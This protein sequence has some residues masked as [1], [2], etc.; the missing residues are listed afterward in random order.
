MDIQSLSQTCIVF[1]TYKFCDDANVSRKWENI[2]CRSIFRYMKKSFFP[3]ILLFFLSCTTTPK[4]KAFSYQAGFKTIR[5]V[6]SS[7]TYKPLTDT[8]DYLHFRPLDLD[9][10]YPAEISNTDSAILFKDFLGLLE[11]RANY[12]T[13]S[14]AANGLT[15]QMAQSCCEGFK[16]SDP[17]KLLNYRT[18]SYRNAKASGQTFPLVIYLASYNSMCYENVALF[19]KL[20][21][22]GYVVLSINS[23]GRYPGDMTMKHGDMMEQVFDAISS[24]KYLDKNTNIDFS[25]IGIVGYSWGG[26]SGTVLANK[27]PNTACLISFDGSEFHHYGESKDE[28][29]DFN[30]IRESADF[31]NMRLQIPYLRLE[32]APLPGTG[33][34]SNVYNFTEKLAGDRIILTIDSTEHQD[35]CSLPSFV[36]ESGNCSNPKTFTT[37]TNLAISF[38]DEHLK[39]SNS[40]SQ[41]LQQELDKTVRQK[42]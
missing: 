8:S 37:I 18:S 15:K 27:I 20:A 30:G 13:A 25:K 5:T 22:N 39:R 21:S 41:T 36:K 1:A 14:T 10:W 4:E 42:N 9:I 38:L 12:Y 19:E 28:D 7:R 35:F 40:F 34:N 11:Q 26:L 23:I 32:S 29:D 31:K 17:D 33:V 24:M 3:A 2:S 16:C 6:D